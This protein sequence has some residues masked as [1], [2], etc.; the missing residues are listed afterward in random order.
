MPDIT[1]ALVHHIATLAAIPI[2]QDEEKKLANG[3]NTTLKVVDQLKS[4]DT[5][6]TE[7]LH[8]VTGLCNVLREDEVDTSRMFTQKQACMNAT[9]SHN[10]FIVVPQILDQE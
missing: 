10:G 1:S 8:Q 2:S 9:Q 6:N 7:P 4:A 5:S 3:F